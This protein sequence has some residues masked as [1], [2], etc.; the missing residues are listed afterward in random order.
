MIHRHT[1]PETKQS[2]IDQYPDP[3]A[4]LDA[5]VTSHWTADDLRRNALQNR[6]PLFDRDLHI[7]WHYV[8]A[9][10]PL[11]DS[12]SKLTTHFSLVKGNNAALQL[13]ILCR[14]VCYIP[15]A[16]GP[17][18]PSGSRVATMSHFVSCGG[19]GTPGRCSRRGIQTSTRA[20]AGNA[21]PS[22]GCSTRRPQYAIGNNS[23]AYDR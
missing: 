5:F 23:R 3:I 11:V 8:T 16:K 9:L 18:P 19:L 1:L 20:L 21:D 14:S 22:A 13:S 15:P 7:L 2:G 10:W 12:W 6:Q 17:T 4:T